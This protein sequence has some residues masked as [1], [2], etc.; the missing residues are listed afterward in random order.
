MIGFY[1]SGIGGKT[2]LNEV[3]SIDPTLNTYYLADDKNCPLGEKTS[4][5]IKQCVISGVKYLFNNGCT[6]V[7]LACNTAT[8]EAIKYLQQEWIPNNYPNKNILGVIRPVAEELMENRLD[9]NSK[10]VILATKATVRTQ[11]YTRDLAQYGYHNVVEVSMGNLAKMIED[12]KYFEAKAII[13]EIL[14][15]NKVL[16]EDAKAIVLACTHYP[17]MREYFEQILEELLIKAPYIISQSTIVAEQLFKYIR[18]HSKYTGKDGYNS[19]HLFHS[20][21]LQ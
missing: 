3:L 2:I 11:Y 7:V 19:K 8:A 5:E 14:T 10:V 21:L 18:K 4:E 20:T 12:G 1:D 15:D 16:I 17:Y 6:L 13:K 9:Q